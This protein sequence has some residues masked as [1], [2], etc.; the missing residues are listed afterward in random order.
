MKC[1]ID[2]IF[3]E[4]CKIA[5]GGDFSHNPSFSDKSAQD[6]SMFL[7]KANLNNYNFIKSTSSLFNLILSD[8]RIPA[9][10]RHI[11]LAKL[12][13]IDILKS[14]NIHFTPATE[15]QKISFDDLSIGTVFLWCDM[16]HVY[17]GPRL[18]AEVKSD[19]SEALCIYSFDESCSDGTHTTE[20]TKIGECSSENTKILL[21]NIF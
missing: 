16:L 12:D 21:K 8:R 6:D 3:N 9:S 13:T 19:L 20:I 17:V 1:S 10:K 15:P 5:A 4:Y 11:M 18:A 7:V 2:E 14:G